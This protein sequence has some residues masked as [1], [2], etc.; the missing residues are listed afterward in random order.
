MQNTRCSGLTRYDIIMTSGVIVLRERRTKVLYNASDIA[1]Y[2]LKKCTDDGF[3]ISNLQLQKILY[4]LQRDFLRVKEQPLFRDEIEAWQ[5]GPVVP[6][7]YYDYCSYGANSISK[8]E[9]SY[10]ELTNG[11]KRI[12]DPI[13]E[14]KQSKYPWDLVEETHKPDGAW[15]YIY[16]DGRGNHKVIPIDLIRQRG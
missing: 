5:F 15:A 13:I 1:K 6:N 12:A 3:P 4:F 16:A 10:I 8:T 11:A 9:D 14:D 2:V 7:V